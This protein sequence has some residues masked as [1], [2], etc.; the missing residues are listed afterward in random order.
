MILASTKILT[1][2]FISFLLTFSTSFAQ[3]GGDD[4]SFKTF[5]KESIQKL[6]K[7]PAQFEAECLLYPLAVGTGSRTNY[8][9]EKLETIS[10]DDLKRYFTNHI[11]ALTSKQGYI[12]SSLQ[13]IEDNL[14]TFRSAYE[15]TPAAIENGDVTVAP[16]PVYK[17][18][19]NNDDV[20]YVLSCSLPDGTF[21]SW[22][23][24]YLDDT[25]EY[26]IWGAIYGE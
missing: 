15:F 18:I 25:Q 24:I 3:K 20:M 10:K 7:S 22:Y 21:L 8:K 12:S 5:L 6:K 13:A 11:K 19:I 23:C 16:D 2:I 4:A 26:K 14:F 1:L 9:Y 17:G